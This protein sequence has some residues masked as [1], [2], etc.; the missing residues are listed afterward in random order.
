M[1][2]N[3]FHTPV[4]VSEVIECLKCR[5]GG[6]YV[7]GTVGGGGHSRAILESISPCGFLVC[8]DRDEEAI[9]RAKQY[10][11]D[12]LSQIVF[13][14]DNFS[15]IKQILAERQVGQVDG[16]LF[17][18]GVSSY[19]LFSKARGFSFSQDGPLDM[20]MDRRQRL[21]AH[22]VINT[23]P[24]ESL[25]EI[26]RTYGEER[27]ASR[28]ARAIVEYRR[29][30]PIS[31]TGELAAIVMKAVSP[32]RGKTQIHPAT[33][34]FMALRIFVNRELDALKEG[35]F[36]AVDCLKPQGRLVVISFHS[37][38]DRIV[39]DTFREVARSCVCPPGIPICTCGGK[40]KFKIVTKRAL[41]PSEKEMNENPRARSAKL[42]AL[43]RN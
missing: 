9:E 23:F 26:I 36:G 5:S 15:R 29:I 16:I 19:Q 4:M 25:A 22:E 10:L 20:R 39:K 3:D 43:E 30:A 17:D 1:N 6:I 38:E 21:T 8:I 13:V 18:L 34:T 24:E 37:L 33:R 11:R 35:L 14:R 40:S 31:T 7:D 28:I 27:Q 2:E 41:K 12:F 32:A 42:R